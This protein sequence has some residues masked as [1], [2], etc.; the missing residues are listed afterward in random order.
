M[1]IESAEE[2]K[3]EPVAPK[4]QPRVVAEEPV[5]VPREQTPPRGL[6][7]PIKQMIR[8]MSQME[9]EDEDKMSMESS[10]G[11]FKDHFLA[12]DNASGS[13]DSGSE[14][15]EKEDEM[16]EDEQED[17]LLNRDI[18]SIP[19][20]LQ[21]KLNKNGTLKALTKEQKDFNAQ[22]EDELAFVKNIIEKEDDETAVGF[23]ESVDKHALQTKWRSIKLNRKPNGLPLD[24]WIN[25]LYYADA[26]EL[27]EGPRRQKKETRF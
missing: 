11:K 3:E 17:P 8:S 2:A 7:T 26:P 22:L 1:E 24:P 19:L 12:R 13:D 23:W 20:I 15:E 27:V 9:I 18:E 5:F 21:T 4:R 6:G 14:S 16:S 10:P 25:E